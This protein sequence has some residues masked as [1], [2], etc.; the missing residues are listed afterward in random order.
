[1]ITCLYRQLTN[2]FSPFGRSN[3]LFWQY[4][5][6]CIPSKR[7]AVLQYFM[8]CSFDD[9]NAVSLFHYCHYDRAPDTITFQWFLIYISASVGRKTTCQWQDVNQMVQRSFLQF[10]TQLP[11]QSIYILC[12]LNVRKYSIRYSKVFFYFNSHFQSKNF[13]VRITHC[14]KIN[15]HLQA[16]LPLI[17]SYFSFFITAFFGHSTFNICNRQ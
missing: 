2:L 14:L 12:C 15:S 4:Q 13:S 3:L 7:Y 10:Y 8:L 9:H 1:M 11:P 5:I 16:Y 6:A 17:D